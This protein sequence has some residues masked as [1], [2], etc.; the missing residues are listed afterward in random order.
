[1]NQTIY[2]DYLTKIC[3][4]MEKNNGEKY[5]TSKSSEKPSASFWDTVTEKMAENN[6]IS[7]AENMQ[8]FSVKDM[9]LEEY[10]QY[11]YGRIADFGLRPACFMAVDITDE[12]FEAMKNDPE[13][14]NH[15]LDHLRK[16][17][18]Y[19]ALWENI[20][21]GAGESRSF[22]KCRKA[23]QRRVRRYIIVNRKAEKSYWK[24]REERR[25]KLQ[26][27]YE[28]VLAKRAMWKRVLESEKA[29]AIHENRMIA[30]AE[31][32][33]LMQTGTGYV[34]TELAQAYGAYEA[35]AIASAAVRKLL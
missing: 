30:R 19:N 31:N 2:V 1:M 10:K 20:S 32:N 33:M 24:K 16:D 14:E 8:T 12:K 3:Q 4:N 15:V 6:K 23:Y 9:T 26:R 7:E 13:Y 18:K 21:K 34:R 35:Y 22:R 11:I 25:R 17:F 28:E 27:Q 5:Y 29:Q